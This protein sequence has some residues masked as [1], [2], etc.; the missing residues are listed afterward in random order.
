ME[1]IDRRSALKALACTAA[2]AALSDSVT[3]AAEPVPV[4]ERG[5]TMEIKFPHP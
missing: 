3:E 4:P 1:H 5:K 2:A